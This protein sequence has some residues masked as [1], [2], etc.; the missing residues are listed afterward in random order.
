MLANMPT[1]P[2]AARQPKL[3][4]LPAYTLVADR[5]RTAV[6]RGQV[7]EGG[8]L[9]QDRIAAAYG[10]SQ[11]I[12]REAFRDLV[13]EGLLTTEPRRGVRVALLSPE[14]AEEITALRQAIEGQVLAW[15]IPKITRA[16]IARAG[17]IVDELDAAQAV[18]RIIELNRRFHAILYE[19]CGRAR[20]LALVETLRRNFARYLRFTWESTQH[21]PRSQSQHRQ[22]LRL[23]A[24]GRIEDASAHLRAHIGETGAVIAE[25]LRA[26]APVQSP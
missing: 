25:A 3:D 8:R 16:D 17:A 1:R 19:P 11:V 23:I 24:G 10:V 5:L 6:L 7:P 26:R 12:V 13:S 9:A 4:N 2:R 21:R 22:L 18:D 15:A 14:E 20:S